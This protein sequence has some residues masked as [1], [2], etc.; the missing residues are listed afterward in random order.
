MPYTLIILC[1]YFAAS[2]QTGSTGTAT[3][4]A[5]SKSAQSTAL[6]SKYKNMAYETALD[7]KPEHRAILM[8]NASTVQNADNELRPVFAKAGFKDSSIDHI[9][10]LAWYQQTQGKSDTALSSDSYMAYVETRFGGLNVESKPTKAFISVDG[11]PWGQTDTQ[12]GLL[13][14]TK[15]VTLHLDGYIDESGEVA[16]VAGQMAHFSRTL[17]KAEKNKP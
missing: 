3:M 11:E 13:V 12:N 14:G 1:F 9:E 6:K 4:Q 8:T 7:A 16:V 17:K 10:A 2:S 15:H 5:N